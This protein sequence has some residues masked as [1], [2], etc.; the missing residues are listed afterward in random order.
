MDAG[1]SLILKFLFITLAAGAVFVGKKY[2]NTKDDNI[3]EEIIE[4]QLEKQTGFNVDL[5]PET[6]EDA[7]RLQR[8]IRRNELIQPID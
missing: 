1:F 8:I 4:Y 5:S 2:F 6:P 7:R 3:A